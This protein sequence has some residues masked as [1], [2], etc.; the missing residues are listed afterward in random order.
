MILYFCDV[1]MESN[2][3]L[4]NKFKLIGMNEA[5]IS[6]ID[7]T[8]IGTTGLSTCVGILLYCEQ[9]KQAIVAH[10]S[11]DWKSIILQ[12]YQ[13][14]SE[15][16]LINST[17]KYKIFQG[18]Y[19]SQYNTE[20]Y[21]DSVFK[22]DK[23]F[24]PFNNNDIPDNAIL[25]NNE[26]FHNSFAFDSESGKFVTDKIFDDKTYLNYLDNKFKIN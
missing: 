25:T 24:I 16:N 23:H 17:F 10:S 19:K 22:D 26:E 4:Y 12:I 8:I 5:N 21:I 7:K 6:T 1:F 3:L 20:Y 14:I 18:Y 2:E 15:H 9:T 11:S 13:L